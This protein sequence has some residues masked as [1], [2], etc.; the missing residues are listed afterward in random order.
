QGKFWSYVAEIESPKLAIWHWQD[1]G[2]IGV[3]CPETGLIFVKTSNLISRDVLFEVRPSFAEV[4]TCAPFP[5]AEYLDCRGQR[6]P[7][8]VSD[9]HLC[10]R[11]EWPSEMAVL[12]L[13]AAAAKA[14]LVSP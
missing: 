14:K 8:A 9:G 13:L 6:K 5:K 11:M 12:V 4:A 7:V 3:W 1:T 10:L 2:P